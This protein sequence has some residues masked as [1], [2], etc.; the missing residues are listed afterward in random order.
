M[1]KDNVQKISS[2][3]IKK[4]I[5]SSNSKL[6]TNILIKSF[7]IKHRRKD[8]KYNTELKMKENDYRVQEFL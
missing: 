3:N 6:H 8:R 4:T 5:C 7:D 2:Q 1:Q